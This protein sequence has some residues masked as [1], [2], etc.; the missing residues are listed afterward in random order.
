MTAIVQ[1]GG[2]KRDAEVIAAVER[3]R[4]GDGLHR[5]PPLPPLSFPPNGSNYGFYDS[6]ATNDLIK[7]ALAATDEQTAADA[8]A[9][10]DKQVMADAAFYPVANLKWST[11]HAAQVHNAV[12]LDGLQSLRPGQR[13][14]RPGQERRLSSPMALLE[15]EDLH[16]SFNTP[17]GVVR[18][19]RGVSFSVERGTHPRHRGRVGVGQVRR[20][21]DDR[22]PDPGRARL[23]PGHARRRR[24]ARREP[25][26]RCAASAARRSA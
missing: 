4:R 11:Y 1:P 5:P 23:G 19:V 17:D 22:R 9:K 21:P 3:G 24:P 18:A 8:W 7:Q 26:G 15:V 20:D 10:A 13:V 6:P 2:S 14:A 25:G 16:V 12:Y